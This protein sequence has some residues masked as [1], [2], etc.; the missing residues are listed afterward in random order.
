MDNQMTMAVTGHKTE[1]SFLTYIKVTKEKNAKRM[2]AHLKKSLSRK[3]LKA[4]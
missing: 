4:V 1:K 3:S 2:M